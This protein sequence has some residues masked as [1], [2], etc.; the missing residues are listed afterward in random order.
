M[1]RRMTFIQKFINPNRLQTQFAPV[2]ISALVGAGLTLTLIFCLHQWYLD[3][4]L[5]RQTETSGYV[6][7]NNSS[8]EMI[9]SIPEGHLFGQNLSGDAPVTN[10]QLHVTGIVKTNSTDGSSPSKAYISIDDKPR[11]IFQPGDVLP[12][13]VKI[14][15]ITED[16]VILDHDGQLEKLPLPRE[17]LTFKPHTT[18]PE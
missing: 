14:Y 4:R 16:T 3:W 5:A 10:L 11:K 17:R 9:A 6:S 15:D 13:G 8:A 2:I 12:Y 1:L 7:T 18:E